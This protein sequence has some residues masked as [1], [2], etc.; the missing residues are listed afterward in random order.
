MC[1]TWI[2]CPSCDAPNTYLFHHWWLE[3]HI[4]LTP[5]WFTLCFW[6]GEK[7]G[8]KRRVTCISPSAP[9]LVVF[10]WLFGSS[11]WSPTF[12]CVWIF[13]SSCVWENIVVAS[14]YNVASVIHTVVWGHRKAFRKNIVRWKIAYK[15]WCQWQRLIDTLF[16][17][18]YTWTPV[19]IAKQSVP[20]TTNKK[21]YSITSSIL[22]GVDD[23]YIVFRTT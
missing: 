12:V 18:D 13:C 23:S 1:H 15:V 5:F 6:G 10:T 20:S 7:L 4:L 2:G 8:C 14:C 22:Y 9:P 11:R 19:I 21:W 16:H 17:S 3:Y